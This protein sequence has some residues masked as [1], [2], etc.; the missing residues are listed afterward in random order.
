M[1]RHS[2]K[3]PLAAVSYSLGAGALAVPAH[4]DKA[5]AGCSG[6]RGPNDPATSAASM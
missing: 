4:L 6:E 3:H 1:G 2:S 5:E